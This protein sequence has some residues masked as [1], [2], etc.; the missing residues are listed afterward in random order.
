MTSQP[1]QNFSQTITGG[2]VKPVEY[3]CNQ[4]YR[5]IRKIGSGSFGDIFLAVNQTSG[6]V[7]LLIYFNT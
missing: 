3:V 1:D 6:E 7:Y 2:N 4:K 5:L